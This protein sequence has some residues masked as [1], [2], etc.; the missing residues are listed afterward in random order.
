MHLEVRMIYSKGTIYRI[1]KL[2]SLTNW[3]ITKRPLIT[4]EVA[5]KW[6][7]RCTNRV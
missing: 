1:L 4:L 3:L 2:Y 7:E 6:L 5:Y